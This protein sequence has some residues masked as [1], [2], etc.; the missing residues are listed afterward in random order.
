MPVFIQ[1]GHFAAIYDEKIRIMEDRELPRTKNRLVLFQLIGDT[2]IVE[3]G[4]IKWRCFGLNEDETQNGERMKDGDPGEQVHHVG[5][6]GKVPPAVDCVG[7]K[8]R[9][10]HHAGHH[11]NREQTGHCAE[12]FRLE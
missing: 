1:E 11:R 5:E 10:C 12:H 3:F 9:N 7:E 6:E 4:A 8:G 2:L